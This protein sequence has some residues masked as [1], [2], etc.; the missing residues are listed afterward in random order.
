MLSIN[1]GFLNQHLCQIFCC[2]SLLSAHGLASNVVARQFDQWVDKILISKLF[3]LPL[4]GDMGVNLLAEMAGMLREYVTQA[5][6]RACIL[7]KLKSFFV[8][9]RAPDSRE[10]RYQKRIQDLVAGKNE[11]QTC[12]VEQLCGM[13]VLADDRKLVDGG[14]G[15]FSS[16]QMKTFKCQGA[17]KGAKSCTYFC[18]E[19][20]RR[21]EPHES[22]HKPINSEAG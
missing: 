22:P 13:V 9:F 6:V 3:A 10:Y 14:G 2:Y 16:S 21:L 19:R 15:Q 17:H 4:Q 7:R 11:K 8:N 20:C 12:T 5:N 1:S 18:K